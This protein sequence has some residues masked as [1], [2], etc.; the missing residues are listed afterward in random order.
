MTGYSLPFKRSDKVVELGGDLERPLFR[1]NVNIIHG[2]AVDIVA[3]LNDPFPLES[4][5]FD[6]VFGN[7]I[8]EH[9]RLTRL[10]QFISEGHRILRPSGT[11]VM[12]TS[13]LLEQSK[14]IVEKEEQN[15]MSD[16]LI[17]MIFG[18]N[19]DYPENYHHSSLS[20][21]YAIKLFREAGFNSVT[22]YEHPVAIQIMGRSTDMILEARKGGAIIT[23]SL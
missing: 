2:P 9:I 21:Q 16:D 12:V 13:N 22:I 18:G 15:Q 6:G 23:R 17:R 8:M 1:P 5:S 19:P 4:G 7:F 14:V 20:P 10:R 11:M 3:D